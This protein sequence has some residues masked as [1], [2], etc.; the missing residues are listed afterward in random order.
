MKI[1]HVDGST[2]LQVPAGTPVMLKNTN[3]TLASAAEIA[4]KGELSYGDAYSFLVQRGLAPQGAEKREVKE[5]K[6][7][8]VETYN[9]MGFCVS[10]ELKPKPKPK[11][12]PKKKAA[13]KKNK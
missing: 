10:K 13:A 8:F 6:D 1:K 11:A 4:V 5:G 3:V 12:K 9:T 2:V 7:T